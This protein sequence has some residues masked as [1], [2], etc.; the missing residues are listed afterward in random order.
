MCKWYAANINQNSE[1]MGS[2]NKNERKEKTTKKNEQQIKTNA[3]RSVG[4]A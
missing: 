1:Q 4:Q 3:I 2:V